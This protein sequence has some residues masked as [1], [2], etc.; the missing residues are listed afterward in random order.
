MCIVPGL[1][2]WRILSK[3]PRWR[4]SQNEN[5]QKLQKMQKKKGNL[6]L[7]NTEYI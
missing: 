5:I 3:T 2:A 1:C 6:V 7:K 4:F